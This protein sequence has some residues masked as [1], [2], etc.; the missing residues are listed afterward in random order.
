MII[1]HEGVIPEDC[2]LGQ[3][4]FVP[5]DIKF[6]L[7]FLVYI[8]HIISDPCQIHLEVSGIVITGCSSVCGVLEVAGWRC[9]GAERTKSEKASCDTD[10]CDIR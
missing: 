8:Y 2:N 7:Q 4:I 10:G 3:S 5:T 9:T 1:N 6:M